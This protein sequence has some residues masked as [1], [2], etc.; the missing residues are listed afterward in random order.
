MV[1]NM[2]CPRLEYMYIYVYAFEQILPTSYLIGKLIDLNESGWG[3]GFSSHEQ[4]SIVISA[5]QSS[6]I[7]HL[8]GYP[9]LPALC[10]QTV[11]GGFPIGISALATGLEKRCPP[12]NTTCLLSML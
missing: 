3:Q 12:L 1:H 2:K 10:H 11:G 5:F 8:A 6:S 7:H 4:L 9:R